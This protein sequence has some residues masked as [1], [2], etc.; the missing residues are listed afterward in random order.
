MNLQLKRFLTTTVLIFNLAV[1]YSSVSMIKGKIHNTSQADSVVVICSTQLGTNKQTCHDFLLDD[2][3]AFRAEVEVYRISEILIAFDENYIHLLTRPDNKIYV[4]LDAVEFRED[5]RIPK[6]IIVSGDLKTTNEL[7]VDFIPMYKEAFYYHFYIENS[8]MMNEL[9]YKAYYDYLTE[10]LEKQS[11]YIDHYIDS[12]AVSD[13]LFI[14]WVKAK[15]QYEYGYHLHRL[16]FVRSNPLGDPI[17]Q[18]YID[19]IIKSVPLN[20]AKAISNGMYG[21]YLHYNLM[22]LTQEFQLSK[23][24]QQM[25]KDNVPLWE[26]KMRYVNEHSDG[27]SKDVMLGETMMQYI[28]RGKYELVEKFLHEVDDEIIRKMI[29]KRLNEAK[30]NLEP[31]DNI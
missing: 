30:K 8:M 6:A 4:E 10:Y 24:G 3:G 1:S 21:M 17:P 11:D 20:D 27:L 29:E 23:E 28:K 7:I 18:W 5:K 25:M 13:S 2:L 9:D 19:K 22:K 15:I 14:H 16:H 12:N 31:I 26:G